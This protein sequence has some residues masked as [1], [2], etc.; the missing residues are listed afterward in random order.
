MNPARL[1]SLC[2]LS[3]VSTG[4][5]AHGAPALPRPPEAR[6]PAPAAVA[7]PRLLA[8]AEEEKEL[9]PIG[10]EAPD[11]SLPLAGGGEV[12]LANTLKVSKLV[13]VVFWSAKSA[14]SRTLFKTLQ[15]LYDDYQDK[16]FDIIAVDPADLAPAVQKYMSDGQFTFKAAVDGKETNHAVAGV[17][18]VH[19]R[20]PTTYLLDPSGKVL[21]RATG[22]EDA[23]LKAALAK[24]GLK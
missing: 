11:F 20:Y 24:A 21:W 13:V 7:A 14:D 4:L 18:H 23:G 8:E 1:I 16:G 15:K 9:L 22:L 6:K 5:P 12:S 17:F 19:G 2:T 10:K 3:F